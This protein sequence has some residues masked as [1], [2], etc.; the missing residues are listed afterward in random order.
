M[1]SQRLYIILLRV[2]ND[3]IYKFGR[4]FKKKS[5]KIFFSSSLFPNLLL[6]RKCDEIK[7]VCDLAQRGSQTVSI[8][9]VL[10]FPPAHVCLLQFLTGSGENWLLFLG[11]V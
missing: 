1:C 3:L 8:F 5:L 4:L 7:G 2:T 9:V 10:V 6:L 11:N